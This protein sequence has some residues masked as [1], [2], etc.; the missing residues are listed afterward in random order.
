MFSCKFHTVFMTG[1]TPNEM[2]VHS[3]IKSNEVQTTAK[4]LKIY[5]FHCRLRAYHFWMK[6]ICWCL[7]V[8]FPNHFFENTVGNF[9]I[10]FFTLNKFPNVA[11]KKNWKTIN[12]RDKRINQVCSMV[13][14]IFPTLVYVFFVRRSDIWLVFNWIKEFD[15]IL[16]CPFRYLTEKERKWA[17]VVSC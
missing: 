15:Y 6:L 17:K 9:N 4:C 7:A 3:R 1:K 5:T 2:R 13:R 14:C 12:Y 8:F 16:S 11:A 10:F